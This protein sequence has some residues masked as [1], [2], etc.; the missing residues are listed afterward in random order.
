MR[1]TVAAVGRAG[2]SPEAVLFQDY[3]RRLP[4]ALTLHE[5]EER[6][7]LKPPELKAREAA[8]LLQSLPKGAAIVALDPGGRTLSSEEFAA[9]LGAWRDE[10]IGDLAFVLGGAAGLDP[11]VIAKARFCLSFGRMTWPHLLARA[12]LAEQL[13]RASAIL[14]GHPYHRG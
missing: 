9:R 2:A 1:L 3:V 14:A 11:G 6:R 4:F 12:M 10:G 13:W 8:L 7:R 5:V